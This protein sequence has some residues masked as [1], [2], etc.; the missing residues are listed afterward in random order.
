MNR[1]KILILA[2]WGIAWLGHAAILPVGLDGSQPY[3][4]IQVAI[5]ASAHGDTVLVHPGT[6]YENI[7]FNGKNI[8]L[9]SLE[10]TTGD[11]SY[12]YNT[13]INGNQRREVIHIRDY[14]SNVTIRGITVTGGSGYYDS[15]YDL[16]AGGGI[17]IGTMSNPRIVNVVNCLVRGNRASS[18][19][20]IQAGSCNLILSGVSIRDNSAD[21]GGG[22]VYASNNAQS[23]NVTFDPVNRSSIYNNKAANGSDMY[24][25]WAN[26]VHVVVDTFTV[27]NPWNF[28]AS[29]VPRDTSISNPYT[30]DIL[31][32][33]HTEVNH[34][35]YVA[36]WGD[37]ANDGLS[38]G[39]PLKT[40]FRA[41]YNI[42]SDPL[43]PKTIHVAEGY[44]SKSLNQQFFP[45]P[46]KNWTKLKG[47]SKERVILDVEMNSYGMTIAAFSNDLSVES[48]TFTNCK[49]GI[50]VSRINNVSFDD[51]TI[52]NCY[53][54]YSSSGYNSNKG[55]NQ[56]L[57]SVTISNVDG[58]SFC[59]GI[60]LASLSGKTELHDVDING[61][62][63]CGFMQ[64]LSIDTV[65][66]CEVELFRSKIHNVSHTNPEW[67][68]SIMQIYPYS[69]TQSQRLKINVR[70]SAFFDNHQAN[71]EN[72][73][74]L[75]ALNDTLFVSNCTFAGNSGGSTALIVQGNAVFTN[76]IFWNP[77]L[78][79]EITAF[80]SSSQGVAGRLVFDHNCIRNGPGGIY[81][82]S[83]LNQI[84]WQSSNLAQDPLFAL[85]GHSPYRLS[86]LSPLIDMGL[87]PA[88]MESTL[89]A[90]GNERYWDGDGDGLAIIDIGAY[91]YQPVYSPINLS[92]QLWQ[93]QILLQWQMPDAPR[94]LSGYRV[95]RNGLAYADVFDAALMQF[96]DYSTVN[97]TLLYYVVALYGN[98]ESAAS[99]SVTV[100]ISGVETQDEALAPGLQKMSISPNPFRDLAVISYNLG[101]ASEIELSI[102]NL[103]GQKVRTLFQGTQP[104]GEQ[105]MA[106]DG[107]DQ[108]GR[109]LASGIYLMRLRLNGSAHHSAKLIKY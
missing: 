63:S 87:Q 97:D 86:A 41:V 31:H 37:D 8:T 3:S 23:Y 12:K 71:P 75:Y 20:G 98:V 101:K 48:I 68:N 80:Y 14:E 95:Y 103:K 106:W 91:E 43:N 6:Y 92:A 94:G 27:A 108:D 102:Y 89:D 9:A 30:F 84:I 83:P 49:S 57:S 70:S 34:D 82:M 55:R 66:S 109:N 28:Y 45:L 52:N 44:Y 53:S 65:G 72:M 32:T 39:S 51:V 96:R 26:Q 74:Y 4:Q 21:A 78:P 99:N 1:I 24:F 2:L 77:Q 107:C 93:Q 19:G 54:L 61:I 104:K 5:D 38:E 88:V 25:Y 90:G 85:E 81:N 46:M 35:L 64:A 59:H 58:Q 100:I 33:V 67:S 16:T 18:G 79:T 50:G 73:S 13:I 62:V 69:E 29:A 76:N 11:L 40:I 105:A 10:L 42:A 60:K 36:P 47:A 15:V 7:R 56:R 17:L 22:L